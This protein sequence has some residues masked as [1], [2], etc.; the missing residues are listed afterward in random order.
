MSTFRVAAVVKEPVAI[1]RRFTDW[2]LAAG[3]ARVVLYFD[4]PD[5]PAIASVTGDPRIEAIRCTPDFWRG[6]G[7]EADARFT[8]RQNAA[9][10]AAYAETDEDWLLV[11]DADELV[12]VTQG[13]IPDLLAA[14]G[15]D[16]SSLMVEPA[17]F[18]HAPVAGA[19]FRLP[20][21]RKF[22]N[23]LYGAEADLF[24]KRHGLIGHS[25]GKAFHRSGQ[26]DIWLR[27]HW[28][29]DKAGEVVPYASVGRDQ[30]AYLLH[31]LAPDFAAWRAKMEWR[32]A[33]TGFHGGVRELIEAIDAKGGDREAGLAALY[34]RM[35]RIDAEMAGKLRAVGAFLELPA[36]FAPVAA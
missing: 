13:T 24:R 9:I 29:V 12:H 21:G 4:D 32:M 20:I 19:A 27:Q 26:K 36:E 16:V 7:Q 10:T 15:P 17:E 18:V 23:R 8:L 5:D 14:Q 11:V 3:A 31:Y 33:S 35:H 22:V 1:L 2:Y 28:A 6:I 25:T 30:G 34:D